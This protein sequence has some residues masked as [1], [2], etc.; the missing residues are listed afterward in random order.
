MYELKQLGE[1]TY[2]ISSPTNIG[3]YEYGGKVCLIDSG[4]DKDAAKKAL[5]QI[6]EQGWKLDM[7]ICTHSHADHSGGCAF[8]K[9]RTDCGVYAPGASAA[10]IKHSFLEPTYLYGGFPVK[11]LCSK[12]LMSMPCDC[13]ELSES[14]LPEGLEIMRIDGHDFGQA[15]IKTRDGVWF[16]ADALL[17]AET[18]SKYK[19]SFLYDIAQHLEALE[20]LE[21]V[22]GRL[23]VPAHA[24]PTEDISGLISINRENVYEVSKVIKGLCERGLTIDELISELFSVYGI[25][26]SI[27]QYS[28]IGC[29]TRS[30]LSWLY[31]AGEMRYEFEG[32]KLV[33]KTVSDT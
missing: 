26:P 10:I 28:L 23:F 15:A 11:E 24:E 25:R 9:E 18:L 33:W 13:G 4:S 32:T 30:Y 27:M 14:V 6:E 16:T 3:V 12:F 20:K 7:V 21:G 22:T 5:R 2:Y 19:I 29:T 1:H 17:S 31:S 8:L